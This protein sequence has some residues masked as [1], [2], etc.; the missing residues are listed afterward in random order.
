MKLRFW[1]VRGSIPCPGPTTLRHGG[2]TPCYEVKTRAGECVI[3][4]AGTGIRGLGAD[5]MKRGPPPPIHLLISHTHWDHIQGFPFF[6]PCYIPGA[7]I[8][9][10]GPMQLNSN[11][12]IEK[13]FQ[14]QMSYEF[15]PI[16]R[17]QLAAQ[18]RYESFG[19]TR[20]KLGSLDAQTHLV[21]HPVL[22]LGYRLTE[23]GRSLV[24]TGDHEPYQ[25]LFKAKPGEA[26]GDE[27][28]SLFGNAD[29]AVATAD[30]RFIEFIRNAHVLLI[31]CT[32]TPE[33]YPSQR[34]GWGHSSWDHCL[35]WMREGGVERMVLTHHDPMRTDD[36]LDAQLARARQAAREQGISS[37]RILAAAEG[38]EIDV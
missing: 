35:R 1:G 25:N 20:F 15:F 26:A 18:I 33:E 30:K 17:Q 9:I 8:R 13:A 6:I 23:D 38:Q 2:N 32:Y 16:S 36:L 3:L 4:D 29:T 37:D 21:N 11:Q 34:R 31:D 14:L 28:D 27:D 24:Y 12:T 22:S 5:L 7:S 19:E 10:T